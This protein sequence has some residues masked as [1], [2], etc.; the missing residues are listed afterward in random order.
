[1]KKALFI[2]SSV[3]LISTALS[4]QVLEYPKV[5]KVEQVD[6]YFGT[7]VSDPYRWLEDDNSAATLE[8]VQSQN[9]VTEK[10]LS[11]I[12]FRDKVKSRLTQLWNF[13]KW[14]VPFKGG[15]N[16]FVHTNDGLQNQFVLNILRSGAGAKP[17]PFLDPN[18]L[19]KDGTVN[20]SNVSV[21]NDGK[22]L[23]YASS[24]AGSDWQEIN[25]MSTTS[26]VQSQDRLEWVKFSSIAWHGK[27]F[28]YSR[29]DAPDESNVLKGKNEFHKVYY[30]AVGNP[31]KYDVLTYQDT[32]NPLRNFSAGTT[33]DERYLIIHGSQG[34]GGNSLA[35]KDLR[36]PNSEFIS[37]ID[38]F[39]NDHAVVDNDSSTLFIL[40]NKNAPKYQLISVDP[41]RPDAPWRTI[42]PEGEDVLEEVHAGH[43]ILI[44]KF[45][46]DAR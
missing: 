40:T 29:Y 37:I 12:P 19:S 18:K 35:V 30:H 46:K 3:L 1:M 39:D 44:A 32:K 25:V 31:Q 27:G 7:K 6:D 41:M 13:P 17:E 14:S 11:A 45:M 10:Y 38:N 33:D 42:I 28:Y 23:A 43:N 22:Y 4:A 24:S 16:Y 8:F 2:L 21:S 34:S 15:N 36:N 20:V 9:K 26:G 5:N